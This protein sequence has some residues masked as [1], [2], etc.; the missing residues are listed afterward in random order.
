MIEL[1]KSRLKNPQTISPSLPWFDQTVVIS[2][3]WPCL[4]KQ[5]CWTVSCLR[6]FNNAFSLTDSYSMSQKQT[7]LCGRITV[8][9]AISESI[10]EMIT[11][12]AMSAH[13]W[14]HSS[15]LKRSCLSLF[16]HFMPASAPTPP[17]FM[18]SLLAEFEYFYGNTC[19]CNNKS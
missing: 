1:Q 15:P 8:R 14:M 10:N 9:W 18:Y 7:W 5:Q 4:W 6:C 12:I 11:F 19:V 2:L 3:C 16:L 17:G 13:T